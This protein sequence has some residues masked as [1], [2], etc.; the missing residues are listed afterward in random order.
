LIPFR[1]DISEMDRAAATNVGIESDGGKIAARTI[2][3]F[4]AFGGAV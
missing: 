4:G 1:D 3:L 2:G